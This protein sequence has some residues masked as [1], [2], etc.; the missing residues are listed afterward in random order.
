M[1]TQV[2]S[3]ASSPLRI[4]LALGTVCLVLAASATPSGA[5]TDR[6]DA[7]PGITLVEQRLIEIPDSRILSLSPDGGSIAVTRPAGSEADRLCVHDTETLVERFCTDVSDLEARLWA[8]TVVWSP[9]SQ[10]LAFGEMWP[11][12][13][14]DGDLW[15]MDASTGVLTNLADDELDGGWEGDFTL[16]QHPTFTPDSSAVTFARTVVQDGQ[17]AGADI[18]TVPILGGEAVPLDDSTR[19]SSHYYG[20]RWTP[21]ESRL[22]VHIIDHQESGYGPDS[23]IWVYETEAGPGRQ[24]ISAADLDRGLESIV[25]ATPRGEQL[26]VRWAFSLDPKPLDRF[27]LI[28]GDSGAVEPLTS[29][30]PKVRRSKPIIGATLSPD[31]SLLLTVSG[32]RGR[33]VAVRDLHATILHQLG[34][35][36]ERFTYKHQGRRFRLTDVHGKI[37]DS[38]LS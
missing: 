22:Y 11:L 34:I 33:Q 15:L 10:W 20:L 23:G 36:H 30:R 1:R 5:A 37:V 28:D 14:T 25:A 17:S 27:A 31:G 6:P 29:L 32:G 2:R 7:V 3:L 16:P 38:I 26:L 19:G 18:A 4:A 9:D 21:D 8:E 35:D 12:Y 24:L 13:F